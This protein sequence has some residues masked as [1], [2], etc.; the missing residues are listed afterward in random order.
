MNTLV[1]QHLQPKEGGLKTLADTG[2][3]A[4]RMGL[5]QL[6]SLGLNSSHLL[7][8]ELNLRAANATGNTILG[9]VFISI[10]GMSSMGKRWR[11]NQLVYVA[12]GLDQL[13][14][15]KEGCE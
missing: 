12:K 13:I 8:P 7:V 3:Q 2:C 10:S 4:C 14:L 5:A 9:A 6:H 15:S 1:H 11:T